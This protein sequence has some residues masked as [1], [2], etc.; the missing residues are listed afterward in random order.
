MYLSQLAAELKPG[1]RI[2]LGIQV[3][4]NDKP[5]AVLLFEEAGKDESMLEKTE[6][7]NPTDKMECSRLID[8]LAQRMFSRIS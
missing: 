4:S 8:F 7:L 3:D 2:I 1:Q 6:L 5:V